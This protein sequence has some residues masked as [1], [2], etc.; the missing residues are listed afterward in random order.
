MGAGRAEVPESDPAML[1]ALELALLEWKPAR[2]ADVDDLPHQLVEDYWQI[3]SGQQGASEGWAWF[4]HG[5]RGL[6]TLAH[7]FRVGPDGPEELARCGEPRVPDVAYR[8]DPEAVKCQRCQA[9]A[10]GKPLSMGTIGDLEQEE[11]RYS[12]FGG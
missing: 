9:K 11:A 7:Q 3:R 10:D 12:P 8:R 5:E 1:S 4:R 2:L 6:V